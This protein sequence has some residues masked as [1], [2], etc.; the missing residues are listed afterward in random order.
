MIVDEFSILLKNDYGTHTQT[1]IKTATHKT[2]LMQSN[3]DTRWRT[4]KEK[5]TQIMIEFD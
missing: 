1:H 4:N 3:Q 5:N 2:G